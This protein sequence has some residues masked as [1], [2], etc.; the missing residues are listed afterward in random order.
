MLEIGKIVCKLVLYTNRSQSHTAF[1]LVKKVVMLND[2][3][4]L[5]FT[6]SSSFWIHYVKLI[7]VR[8]IVYMIKM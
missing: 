5:H 1:S 3:I 4:L 7:Q 6:H 2:F 8:R